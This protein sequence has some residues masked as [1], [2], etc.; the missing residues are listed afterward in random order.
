MDVTSHEFMMAYETSN[1]VWKSGFRNVASRY[2]VLPTCSPT[3]YY[4]SMKCIFGY[5]LLFG[6]V[7]SIHYSFS[8]S[9]KYSLSV[10]IKS[11]VVVNSQVFDIISF[12]YLNVLSSF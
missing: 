11:T 2:N 1:C 10:T 12:F 5:I 3:F 6:Q 4:T 8:Q 7:G 9:S